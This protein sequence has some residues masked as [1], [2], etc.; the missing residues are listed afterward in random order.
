MRGSMLL[1]LTCR[2]CTHPFLSEGLWPK[3]Y[4]ASCYTVLL[5][6]ILAGFSTNISFYAGGYKR[7]VVYLCWPLAPLY[8]SPD[9]RGMGGGVTGSQ[10]MSTAVHIT[11]HGA[12][13]NFG[14]LHI[15]LCFYLSIFTWPLPL[16]RPQC[17]RG[18]RRGGTG[19]LVHRAAPRNVSFV[20]L[21]EY[22]M[23]QRGPGFLAVE[24]FGSWPSPFPLSL[25][26]L[27]FSVF[28]CFP[29]RAYWWESDGGGVGRIQI[30]RG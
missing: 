2:L 28:L 26:C 24:R 19:L 6:Y 3:S 13:I 21:R 17:C 10:P 15:Y 1:A 18:P 20:N 22:L 12:P 23:Y 4:L 9:A 29:G 27:P 8:T 30:L 7:D 11:W 5:Y 16:R 25:R 14:D